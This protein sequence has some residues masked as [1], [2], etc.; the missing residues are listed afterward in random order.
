VVHRMSFS[1]PAEPPLAVLA[2][3]RANEFAAF[4]TDGTVQVFRLPA[5]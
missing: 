1:A 2:G 4:T 3:D 5:T